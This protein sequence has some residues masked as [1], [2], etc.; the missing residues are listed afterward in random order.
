[1]ISERSVFA[2][3]E[4]TCDLLENFIKGFAVGEILKANFMCL[5]LIII[6]I[7]IGYSF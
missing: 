3:W 4:F 6:Q 1:M 2:E 7:I 5:G